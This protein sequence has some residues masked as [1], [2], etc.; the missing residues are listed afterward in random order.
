MKASAGRFE[1]AVVERTFLY[2]Q[3]KTTSGIPGRN[4]LHPDEM[5]SL[6]PYL[7]LVDVEPVPIGFRFRLVG[8]E[9]SRWAGR[10]YTGVRVNEQE[11]GPNW[12]LVF[13]AYARVVRTGEPE[14]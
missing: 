1:T 3:S 4:D 14:L 2:W 9:I 6:L 5:R 11:Y 13:Q 12:H 7:F 10:E 8:T